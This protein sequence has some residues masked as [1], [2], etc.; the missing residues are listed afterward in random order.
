MNY[1]FIPLYAAIYIWNKTNWLLST[2]PEKLL[3]LYRAVMGINS[4]HSFIPFLVF[5]SI[6]KLDFFEAAVTWFQVGVILLL[7]HCDN[8]NEPCK[9]QDV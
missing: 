1:F 5:L 8:E 2:N 7:I 4:N 3:G 9:K 6:S